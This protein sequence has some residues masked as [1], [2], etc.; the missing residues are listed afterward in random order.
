MWRHYF[1]NTQLVIYVVD[2]TRRDRLEEN[3]IEISR[4]LYEDEMRDVPLLVLV[5]KAELEDCIPLNEVV[6][7]LYLKSIDDRKVHV[8]S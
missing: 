8:A 2:G 5:N 6:I 3:K 7:G 4:I 1:Q